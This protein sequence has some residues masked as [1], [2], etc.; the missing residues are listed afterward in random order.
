MAEY[1]TRIRTDKGD[2]Q[3]DYNYLANLPISDTTLSQSGKFADAKV[4]GDK[5]KEVSDNINITVG[6]NIQNVD[7]IV[8]SHLSKKASSTEDGHMTSADKV[9]LDGIEEGANKYVLPVASTNIIGGVKTTSNV[10]STSG[11]TPCPIISGVPYYD[12]TTLSDLGITAT[13]TELNKLSGLSTVAEKAK[14]LSVTLGTTWSNNKQTVSVSGVT[15]NSLVAVAANPTKDN[16]NACNECGV[17][18]VSQSNG[19]LT[20]ECEYVPTTQ[21]IM[22]VAIFA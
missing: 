16:Y 2:M 3:I 20:F 21:I 1:I 18:C 8:S 13:A 14:T 6:G 5:I 22:N 9:K 12:P 17:R 15:A 10:T 7:S 19:S 11:L 4:V